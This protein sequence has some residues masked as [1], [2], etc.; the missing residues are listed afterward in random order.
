MQK[1]KIKKGKT[2]QIVIDIPE[3]DYKQGTLGLYFGCY[4]MKL[5]DTILNG[6]SLP[7][8]HGRLI[9][10]DDAYDVLGCWEGEH[11][12]IWD[13]LSEEAPTVLEA[14]MRGAE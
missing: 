7:K 4:S 5:H 13:K 1:R 12:W 3:E 14:D 11:Q 8:G 9:D 6:T 10:A 2:M